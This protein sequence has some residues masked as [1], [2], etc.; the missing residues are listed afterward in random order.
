[1][2]ARALRW[3]NVAL[4]AGSEDTAVA[5]AARRIVRALSMKRR[6]AGPVGTHIVELSP[7]YFRPA[8]I[9]RYAAERAWKT[10]VDGLLPVWTYDAVA[11]AGYRIRA[12]PTG[13]WGHYVVLSPAMLEAAR[14]LAGEWCAAGLLPA[15][16]PDDGEDGWT[17]L[18]ISGRD[19]GA[20]GWQSVRCPFHSDKTP[21]S[22]VRWNADGTSGGFVC[23]AC[24]REDEQGGRL[25]GFAIRRTNGSVLVRRTDI[26]ENDV[27]PCESKTKRQPSQGQAHIKDIPPLLPAPR[28]SRV[29]RPYRQPVR[30]VSLGSYRARGG[31]TITYRV[32]RHALRGSFAETMR[33][34]DKQSKRQPDTS[35]RQP[36]GKR[37]RG[38]EQESVWDAV[39]KWDL[40][41]GDVGLYFADRLWTVCSLAPVGEVNEGTHWQPAD[42][43]KETGIER[44]LFDVDDID[45]LD[46]EVLSRAMT[47]IRA[48]LASDVELRNDGAAVWTS[49]TGLQISALLADVRPV[50]W[51]NLPE[52]RAWYVELGAKILAALRNAGATDGHVDMAS[53]SKGRL[54]RRPGWRLLADGTPW[55]A[56]LVDSWEDNT[57]IQ[58]GRIKNMSNAEIRRFAPDAME[59]A[60]R[61]EILRLGEVVTTTRLQTHLYVRMPSPNV[62]FYVDLATGEFHG[63]GDPELFPSVRVEIEAIVSAAREGRSTILV[64]QPDVFA[65]LVIEPLRQVPGVVAAARW[66]R[67]KLDRIYLDLV[68]AEADTQATIY[69]NLVTGDVRERD[70][71]AIPKSL[72][73]TVAQVQALSAEIRPLSLGTRALTTQA[74]PTDSAVA[75]TEAIKPRLEEIRGV[76]A[77]F[78]FHSSERAGAWVN[79]SAPWLGPKI[80]AAGFADMAGGVFTCEGT[81]HDHPAL[82]ETID[83]IHA[84]VARACPATTRP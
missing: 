7:G 79:L 51:F 37:K 70:G 58:R 33:R 40:H 83:R 35:E 25:T 19:A 61:G 32:V 3:W 67:E 54:G 55:R 27:Q 31:E 63:L 57:S 45:G 65:N 78:P 24:S 4:V 48:V 29:P 72:R 6:L 21:S 42:G 49:P 8:G 12:S 10:I 34:A 47:E 39:A 44:V 17:P 43:W 23:H 2:D 82:R 80:T 16:D 73:G 15:I 38:T 71:S 26:V 41:G 20:S 53:C 68:N 77:V 13:R 69:L 56:A 59:R 76:A 36:D 22:S 5:N 9:S 18:N 50:E 66:Q 1:M 14:M 30:A 84:V 11:L 75:R 64:S 81:N 46:P 28:L 62:N 74:T 60:I 52:T